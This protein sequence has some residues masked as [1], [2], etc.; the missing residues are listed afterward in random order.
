MQNWNVRKALEFK[1]LFNEALRADH[2]PQS[3]LSFWSYSAK[4]VKTCL[5]E[6]DVP[7]K[8]ASKLSASSEFILVRS[9]LLRLTSH[10]LSTKAAQ[11]S[12]VF[13]SNSFNL[14]IMSSDFSINASASALF[15][16]L[17]NLKLYIT[18]ASLV[19]RPSP[20]SPAWRTFLWFEDW[21]TCFYQFSFKLMP[22]NLP[23]NQHRHQEPDLYSVFTI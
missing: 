18:P 17:S 16:I 14:D 22:L 11:S 9:G 1:H 2:W 12:N 3:G 6:E 7:T 15:T 8:S 21:G 5:L 13:S 20:V 4:D 23:I 10:F 19:K